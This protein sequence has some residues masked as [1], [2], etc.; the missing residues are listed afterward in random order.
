MK[1]CWA[2]L[3]A[4]SLCISCI[5]CAGILSSAFVRVEEG[6]VTLPQ[7][8]ETDD[9]FIGWLAMVGMTP[10]LLPPG[11]EYKAQ[12]EMVFKPIS[13][14]MYME[15]AGSIRTENPAGLRFTTKVGAKGYGTLQSAGVA[16]SFGTLIAPTDSIP[17]EFTIAAFEAAG[18]PYL[19]IETNVWQ[20][21]TESERTYTAVLADLYESNYM[22]SF[23]AVPYLEI[24]YSD[25]ST[26][27][28]Y[29]SYEPS[30][31]TASVYP[32]A[33]DALANAADYT[34]EQLTVFQQYYDGVG[35]DIQLPPA[36]VGG[37]PEEAFSNIDGAAYD[38]STEWMCQFVDSMHDWFQDDCGY[39]ATITVTPAPGAVFTEN[40]KLFFNGEPLLTGYTLQDGALIIT[41]RYALGHYT[42][43]Y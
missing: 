36:V 15:S 32:L 6:W 2:M 3:I 28:F 4:V 12:G 38:V 16:F 33:V 26:G 40:T 37:M 21:S 7:Y 20:S 42:W 30:M 9:M 35:V 8:A 43:A 19:K 22:R 18:N 23:S 41:R 17:D 5:C 27:V 34:D 25:G 14:S 11:A 31:H 13:I 24:E 1:K 10:V 29:G 39:Q